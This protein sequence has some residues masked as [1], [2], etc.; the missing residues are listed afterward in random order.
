MMVPEL[1]PMTL[2]GE[3]GVCALI[4]MAALLASRERC[5]LLPW[6]AMKVL[7]EKPRFGHPW[8]RQHGDASSI[9]DLNDMFIC[10]CL[11]S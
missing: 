8:S 5:W 10:V 7:R 11:R 2:A 9:L 6:A 3:E 4:T 1:L